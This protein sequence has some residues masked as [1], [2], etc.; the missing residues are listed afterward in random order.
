[1]TDIKHPEITVQLVGKNG[2]AFYILG[3]CK[4]A[5]ERNHLPQSEIDQFMSEATSG[6]YFAKRNKFNIR[7]YISIK[8]DASL[9]K[10]VSMSRKVYPIK[11]VSSPPLAS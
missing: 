8:I 5:M 4:S 7:K 2:N 6:D 11:T 9:R 1:M 10:I 3:L